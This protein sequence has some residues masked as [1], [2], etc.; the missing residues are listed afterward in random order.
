MFTSWGSEDNFIQFLFLLQISSAG[1]SSYVDV[2]APATKDA[3]NAGKFGLNIF[4]RHSIQTRYVE[5]E[6]DPVITV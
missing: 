5:T 6:E 4:S 2:D 1:V 3:F